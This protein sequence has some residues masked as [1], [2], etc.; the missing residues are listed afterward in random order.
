MRLVVWEQL[1]RWH[2]KYIEN[3][4]EQRMGI[5]TKNTQDDWQLYNLDSSCWKRYTNAQGW[6]LSPEDVDRLSKVIGEKKVEQ[7]SPAR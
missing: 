3:G 1:S 6:T 2:K 7:G 4:A 5:D